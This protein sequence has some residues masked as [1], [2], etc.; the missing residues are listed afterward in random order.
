MIQT[1]LKVVHSQEDLSQIKGESIFLAGPVLRPTKDNPVTMTFWREE[2]IKILEEKGFEGTVMVPEHENFG[3][4]FIYQNQVEWEDEALKKATMIIFWVPR[5]FTHLPGFTTNVEFG[6][7]MRSGKVVLGYPSSAVKMRY[8]QHKADKLEIKTANTLTETVMNALKEMRYGG[9]KVTKLVENPWAELHLMRFKDKGTHGYVYL[10]DSC[11]D[12]V[13]V[14]VLPYRKNGEEIEY[15][16]RSEVTPCWHPTEQKIS[17]ITGGYEKS[18]HDDV[19]HTAIEELEE[20]AGY[21]AERGEIIS[22]GQTYG[23]KASDT[24]Y[25]IFA[26]DVTGKEQVDAKGDGSELEAQA[27]CYWTDENEID[28]AVDPFVYVAH[29]KLQKYLNV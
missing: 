12:G 22:L 13:K 28:K 2:A 27:H 7:W 5:D 16:L 20:E 21:V 1:K 29:R 10:H 3:G 24:I 6:E 14:V 26:V 8:L 9:Y 4:E 19:I 18:K 11:C 25:H 23:Q 17:S 15:M